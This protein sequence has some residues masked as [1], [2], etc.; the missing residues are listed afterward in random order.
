MSFD[1]Y[2]VAFYSQDDGSWVAEIPGGCH[3]LMD[4]HEATLRASTARQ[5]AAP[6]RAR[7]RWPQSGKCKIVLWD[8]PRDS[9]FSLRLR[10]EAGASDETLAAEIEG[11]LRQRLTALRSGGASAFDERRPIHSVSAHG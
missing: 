11:Q 10:C 7:P 5:A 4:T 1:D 8:R 3:T 9:Y 2:K 6:G